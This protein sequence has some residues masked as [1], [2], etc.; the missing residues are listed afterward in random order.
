[1]IYRNISTGY[2]SNDLPENTKFEMPITKSE[3]LS[4]PEIRIFNTLLNI[5][6][7]CN[8]MFLL[9]LLNILPYKRILILNCLKIV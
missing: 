2:F 7:S 1:M 6:L 8:P 4:K 9:L 5:K 3:T